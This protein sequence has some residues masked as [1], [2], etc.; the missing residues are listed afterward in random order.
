MTRPGQNEITFTYAQ[1][2][3]IKKKGWIELR[4]TSVVVLTIVNSSFL[5]HIAKVR[6]FYVFETFK[7]KLARWFVW[8]S[9]RSTMISYTN[10]VFRYHSHSSLKLWFYLTWL[11]NLFFFALI[12]VLQGFK[13][14]LKLK[15][16]QFI[17]HP[18]FIRKHLK[19]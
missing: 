18:N 3:N 12:I 7:S 2:L 16:A 1:W 11:R 4:F 8:I 13:I 9:E 17:Q 5:I 10:Y 14:C 6:D 15:N 19:G